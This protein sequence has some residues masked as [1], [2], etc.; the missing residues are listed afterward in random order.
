M[1][2][3]LVG[4]FKFF[5]YIRCGGV[6]AGCPLGQNPTRGQRLLNA[7]AQLIHLLTSVQVN[8][9]VADVLD[10]AFSIP[11]SLLDVSCHSRASLGLNCAF[12]KV[13]AVTRRV[14]GGEAPSLL[15]GLI[16]LVTAAAAAARHRGLTTKQFFL[17][18]A[19]NLSPDRGPEAGRRR[20]RALPASSLRAPAAP[21]TAQ[22]EW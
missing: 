7:A 18:V 3:S 16:L 15:H 1:P 10:H 17:R 11:Y 14:N 5:K 19:R 8:I 13:I 9:Y 22:S 12:F 6:T 20:R 4:V 21:T 2:T